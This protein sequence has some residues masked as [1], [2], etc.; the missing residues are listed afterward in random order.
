M[1]QLNEDHMLPITQT[2]R[3]RRF[4][5][6]SL[7]CVPLAVGVFTAQPAALQQ[8]G[9]GGG[10]KPKQEGHDAKA[11][12]ELDARL[13]RVNQDLRQEVSNLID[14]AAKKY[15][16]SI[17]EEGL[18]VSSLGPSTMIAGAP[19]QG[20][21]DRIKAG[22][23]KGEGGGK[24]GKGQKAGGGNGEMQFQ[25]PGAAQDPQSKPGKEGKAGKEG[26]GDKSAK[27]S[28]NV[29]GILV[30]AG[31]HGKGVE[32]GA[33]LGGKMDKG[34]GDIN[35]GAYAVVGEAGNQMDRV[36]L[37]GEDGKVFATIKVKQ[38]AEPRKMQEDW[39]D[40][41]YMSILAEIMP[42]VN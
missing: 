36:Q 15:D 9:G 5:S 32:N 35:S 16:I 3:T 41:V 29:L 23:N 31:G 21:H 28:D 14:S 19:V 34:P 33:D 13:K 27:T 18:I 7:L 20:V 12:G 6:L 38:G 10:N 37:V 11:S 30:M 25:D 4:F 42:M 22:A 1:T 2:G 26:K 39:W 24:E 17:R 40:A 8:D